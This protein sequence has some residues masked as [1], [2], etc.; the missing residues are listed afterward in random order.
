MVVS[1]PKLTLKEALELASRQ[2]A[3]SPD[4][5]KDIYKRND[6]LIELRRNLY[7]EE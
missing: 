7:K 6:K 1:K 3:E 2:V 4:W 5:L